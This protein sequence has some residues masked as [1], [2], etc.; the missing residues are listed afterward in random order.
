MNS[1]NYIMLSKPGE[2]LAEPKYY[3]YK[4]SNK[5]FQTIRNFAKNRPEQFQK[6]KY[7]LIAGMNGDQWEKGIYSFT[8]THHAL[9]LPHIIYDLKTDKI[10]Q[11][12]GQLWKFK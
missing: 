3:L 12:E 4:E 11:L 6:S 9:K 10:Y 8:P 5:R 7:L 1:E 2:K